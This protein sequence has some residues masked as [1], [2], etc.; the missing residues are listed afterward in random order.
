MLGT[1][2]RFVIRPLLN[3]RT[4][5]N[6]GSRRNFVRPDFGMQALTVGQVRNAPFPTS[7]EKARLQ[8]GQ[9][10]RQIALDIGDPI[11]ITR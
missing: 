4:P 2:L 3:P 11:S 7:F 8:P 6:P 5:I 9:L 10:G 1:P